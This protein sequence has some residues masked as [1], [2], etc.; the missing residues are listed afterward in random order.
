MPTIN[1]LVSKGREKQRR[2]M[3]TPALQMPSTVV[4]AMLARKRGLMR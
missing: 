1:Q 3:A 2:K 4:I